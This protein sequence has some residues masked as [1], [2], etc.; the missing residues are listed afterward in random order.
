LL[1]LRQRWRLKIWLYHIYPTRW[2]LLALTKVDLNWLLLIICWLS[3]LT[4]TQLLVLLLSLLM[5]LEQILRSL[6]HTTELRLNIT[7][8]I[9]WRRL[10]LLS[11]KSIY[12]SSVKEASILLH[13]RINPYSTEMLHMVLTSGIEDRRSR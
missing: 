3:D 4:N 9:L 1:A 2:D 8:K 12:R 6:W 5:L 11:E 13:L 10:K 7:I